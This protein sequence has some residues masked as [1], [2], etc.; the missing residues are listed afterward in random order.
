MSR[1]TDANGICVDCKSVRFCREN[2]AE[3]QKYDKLKFYE[4][5]EEKLEEVYGECPDLLEIA[6][7]VLIKHEGFDLG[8]QLKSKLLTDETVDRWELWKK[9]DA[10]GRLL[11][12]PCKIGDTVY[13]LAGRFGNYCEQDI[14]DGFYIGRN[15]NL[16]VKVQNNKGNHGTYCKISE[17]AF[18]TKEEAEQALKKM[19][20]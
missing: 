2:C 7:N 11:E 14:C 12:L 3:K 10:E 17:T 18:L 9:A 19:E 8:S 4:D 16:Q 13:I 5:L 6:I 15:C 20:D 1:L